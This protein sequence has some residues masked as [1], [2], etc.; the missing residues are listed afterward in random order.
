MIKYIA[1][2]ADA[3]VGAVFALVAVVPLLIWSDLNFK[4]KPYEQVRLVAFV[5]TSG[6]I[7][8]TASFVK[9]GDCTFNKLGAFVLSFEDGWIS[10]PW[11]DRD[12]SRGDRLAGDQV[13]S[14]TVN[15]SAAKHPLDK[16]E[17]RTRHLCGPNAQKVDR[18]FLSIP[19][20]Q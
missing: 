14:I 6:E 5:E 11:Q 4:T 2:V 13:L 19:L 7:E 16:L 9:N 20:T 3:F 8:L 1:K 17:V 10:V 12:I 18:I 15:T